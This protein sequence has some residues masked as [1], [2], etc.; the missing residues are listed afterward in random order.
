MYTT[1]PVYAFVDPS[2]LLQESGDII[3]SLS[4]NPNDRLLLRKDLLCEAAPYF[5]P[6]LGGLRSSTYSMSADNPP[7]G[8]SV[9]ST[10][11]TV[12]NTG[13]SVQ[14][15]RL[16]IDTSNSAFRKEIQ[17]PKTQ[18]RPQVGLPHYGGCGYSPR[19]RVFEHE[20]FETGEQIAGILEHK[21]LFNLLFGRS[22]GIQDE[23]A[24]NI[25][26]TA[27]EPLQKDYSWN[28]DEHRAFL[29]GWYGR[30]GWSCKLKQHLV[31]DR[32]FMIVE[33]LMNVAVLAQYYM[34]LPR[35]VAHI[36]REL[37]S[38]PE[39]WLH[40][41][42]QP[43]FWIGF[44]QMLR[45]KAAFIEAVRHLAAGCYQAPDHKGFDTHNCAK[46]LTETD[47]LDMYNLEYIILKA[48][49]QMLSL[50]NRVRFEIDPLGLTTVTIHQPYADNPRKRYPIHSMITTSWNWE[51]RLI[52]DGKP[53]KTI[54]ERVDFIARSLLAQWVKDMCQTETSGQR[55]LN[56]ITAIAS[57]LTYDAM[58]FCC[59]SVL[60]LKFWGPCKQIIKAAQH[61]DISVFGPNIGNS[62]ATWFS[63]Y[64]DGAP[65]AKL[66]EVRLLGLLKETE[67]KIRGVMSSV[68]NKQWAKMYG[69]PPMQMLTTS[70][71]ASSTTWSCHGQRAMIGG[72]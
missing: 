22:C 40:M 71:I 43:Q 10:S 33:L 21:M 55:G 31:S 69:P 19:P 41:A 17:P 3:L 46:K 12:P 27:I 61:K 66:I 59:W 14:V 24:I 11:V 26:T 34:C 8:W 13:Q 70:H 38:L 18:L 25:Q 51:K 62:V 52:E 45:W 63:L 39:I 23:T 2:K 48:R 64:Q 7:S 4:R 58:E 5:T 65:A 36:V 42:Q 9:T 44:A 1:H 50:A 35:V 49:H 32:T 57:H 37:K 15:Y 29:V 67:S 30:C 16:H 47:E 54:S 20:R 60:P 28:E 6:L 53:L 72:I 68:D 56:A